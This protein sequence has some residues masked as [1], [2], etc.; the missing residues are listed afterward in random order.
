M[1][2]LMLGHGPAALRIHKLWAAGPWDVTFWSGVS[3]LTKL[4]PR[5]PR[6]YSLFA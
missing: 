6:V 4:Y 3:H 5:F 1:T 2:A